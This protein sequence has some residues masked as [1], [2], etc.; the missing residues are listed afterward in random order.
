MSELDTRW[1]PKMKMENIW[2]RGAHLSH[3]SFLIIEEGKYNE[4]VLIVRNAW[5]NHGRYP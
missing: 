3:D 1:K 2:D 4:S 5:E